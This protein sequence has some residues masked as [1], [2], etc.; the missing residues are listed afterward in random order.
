[1]LCF[2]PFCGSCSLSPAP[3]T[4]AAKSIADAYWEFWL[5]TNPERATQL[6]EYRYNDQLSEYSIGH[7]EAVKKEALALA[8]RLNAIDVTKLNE[9]DRLDSAILLGTLEDLARSIDLKKYEMPV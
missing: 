7:Y 9:A 8:A 5:R 3:T 6:G 2:A 4:D 1:M